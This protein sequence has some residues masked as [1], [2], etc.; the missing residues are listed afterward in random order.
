MM[1]KNLMVHLDQSERC[2]AR[3]ALAVSLAKKH[4]ARLF[5]VFAQRGLPR[6]VGVVATW[7][8]QQYIDARTASKAAFESAAAALPQSEWHDINRGSDGEILHHVTQLARHADLV[9]LGQ[10]DDRGKA[11][12]PEELVDEVILDAGC[13]VLVL[14][15]AGQFTTVGS[16]PLIAWNDARQAAH[17]LLDALPLILDCELATVVTFDARQEEAETSCSE[18]ARHLACHGIKSKSE[19]ILVKDIGIMDMLLNRVTDRGAD[20]LVMGAHG[21]IGFPFYSR[22]AGTRYILKHMTVPVLMSN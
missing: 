18:V 11:Y 19:V 4:Q 13:P 14:P 9:V 8:S 21:H 20:L 15:Y 7:P 3:L 22:G 12:V 16:R 5:G 2:A 1:L 17:A 6:Q 10:H